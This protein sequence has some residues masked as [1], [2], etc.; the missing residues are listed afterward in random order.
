[1]KSRA[2]NARSPILLPEVT[3]TVARRVLLRFAHFDADDVGHDFFSWIINHW[4]WF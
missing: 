2:E 4:R 1:M 3:A